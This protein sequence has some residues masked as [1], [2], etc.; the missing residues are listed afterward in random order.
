MPTEDVQTATNLILIK[1]VPLLEKQFGY[2][3]SLRIIRNVMRMKRYASL[4]STYVR[5]V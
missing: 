5:M 1:R 3:N 2:A 4:H